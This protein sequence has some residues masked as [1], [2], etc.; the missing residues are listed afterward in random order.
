MIIVY[1][2]YPQYEL[3]VNLIIFH[4]NRMKKGLRIFGHNFEFPVIVVSKNHPLG[5]CW[6][7]VGNPPFPH[8]I[9]SVSKAALKMGSPKKLSK[10]AL[11]IETCLES[12]LLEIC[13]KSGGCPLGVWQEFAGISPGVRWESTGIH[14]E[15]AG[16]PLGIHLEYAGI[17]LGVCWELIKWSLQKSSPNK[18]TK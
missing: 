8:E 12:T 6:V 4:Y 18:V 9:L 11:W 16:S 5:L 13:W 1:H 14:L 3:L 10:W 15:F 17:P 7:S 2:Y